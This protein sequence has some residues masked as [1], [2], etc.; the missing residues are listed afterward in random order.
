MLVEDGT[1]PDGD[2]AAYTDAVPDEGF[3]RRSRD[4]PWSTSIALLQ[5]DGT[6]KVKGES[7]NELLTLFVIRLFRLD[8]GWQRGLLT[9]AGLE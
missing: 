1:W 7:C 6:S 8:I 3:N 5:Q 2:T 9:R 4:C